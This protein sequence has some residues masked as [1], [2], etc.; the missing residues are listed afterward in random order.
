MEINNEINKE[1]N[2]EK[3]NFFN[4]FIGKS[5]NTA[6]NIGLKT[7]LPDLIE[8]QIIEIKDALFENGLKSGINKAIESIVDIGKGTAGIFTGKFESMS[9]MEVAIKNGGIIDSISELLDKT[10]DLINEKGC[11]NKTTAKLIEG[12]K[13]IIL[14]SIENNIKEEINIQDN[15]IKELENDIENWK[16]YY[17]NKDFEGMTEVYNKI[18]SNLDKIIPVEDILIESKKINNIYDLIKNNGQDF[19]ITE[20]EME[21]AEKLI[22]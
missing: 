22:T 10:I 7:I 6:I 5:I 14:N 2:N 12:G 21:L 1:I 11:I 17:E 9:Q 8:D 3:N 18:N 20:V 16:Q 15:M 4:N 13:D 19:N